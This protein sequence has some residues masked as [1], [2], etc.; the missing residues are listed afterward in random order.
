[1]PAADTLKPTHK[2]IKSYREALDAYAGQQVT[3]EGAT[4]TAFQR[5]LSDAARSH[6]WMLVPKLG[7]KRGGKS[8]TPDGTVR[9]PWN[10]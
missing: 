1:M 2:A 6:G 9:A 3:H 5:L 4:E 10:G 7:I 8:I